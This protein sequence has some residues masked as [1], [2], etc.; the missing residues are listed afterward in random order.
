MFI[1]KPINKLEEGMTYSIKSLSSLLKFINIDEN[2]TENADEVSITTYKE[3]KEVIEK[4]SSVHITSSEVASF[5]E[6]V[7]TYMDVGLEKEVNRIMIRTTKKI[8]VGSIVT[9]G[10][11]LKEKD[12]DYI[13]KVIDFRKEKKQYIVGDE[14]KKDEFLILDVVTPNVDDV[15]LE[16]DIYGERQA[17]LEGIIDIDKQTIIDNVLDN[18]GIVLLK[19]S[20]KNALNN[21]PTV[22]S[23]ASKLSTDAEK[24][25]F[26]VALASFDFKKPKVKINVKGTELSF[27]I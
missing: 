20:I 7:Y 18:E 11:N 6:N 10:D 22:L 19:N 13:C 3:E 1:L 4:K 16:L 25:D 5:E 12:S 27:E 2:D 23:Y 14:I 26:M 15:Y 21:S 17:T 8:R 9:I 24:K